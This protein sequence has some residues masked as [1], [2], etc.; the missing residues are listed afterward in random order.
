MTQNK[1]PFNIP[2]AYFDFV[3]SGGI[4]PENSYHD[5]P[6]LKMDLKEKV[7]KHEI[8]EWHEDHYRT[9]KIIGYYLVKYVEIIEEGFGGVV[10]LT[11]VG[12][13]GSIDF[14][15]HE[16]WVLELYK[17]WEELLDDF[18][19]AC[20]PEDEMFETAMHNVKMYL[21]EE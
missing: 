13:F 9:E 7:Y 11:E 2:Q 14:E 4:L 5:G 6:V 17:T 18:D 15:H 12:R 1:T 10:W 3:E 8:Y 20:A 21:I 16:V 19:Y